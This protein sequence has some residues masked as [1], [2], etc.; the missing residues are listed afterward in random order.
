MRGVS[1]ASVAGVLPA[2]WVDTFEHCHS[3]TQHGILFHG[4]PDGRCLLEQEELLVQSFSTMKDEM[5]QVIREAEK[6]RGRK[7]N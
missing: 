3:V 5:R 7:R 1:T 4:W 2:L 6:K